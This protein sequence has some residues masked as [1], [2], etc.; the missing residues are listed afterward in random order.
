[1]LLLFRLFLVYLLWRA[2]DYVVLRVLRAAKSDSQQ[3]AKGGY[4]TSQDHTASPQSDS[5]QMWAYKVLGVTPQSTDDEI[6]QAYRRMAMLYHPDRTAHL[7]D[8][9]RLTAEKK[10]QEL[11]QA[12]DYIFKLRG[13]H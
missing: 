3:K 13:I 8:D 10:F 1:M 2:F 7:G 5:R 11:G 9:V 4:R 6:K 12:R